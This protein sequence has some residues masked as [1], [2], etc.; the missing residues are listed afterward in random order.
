VDWKYR[1]P[2]RKTA[3]SERPHF[4]LLEEIVTILGNGAKQLW[5]GTVVVG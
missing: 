3:H 5:L 4:T 1:T 2:F